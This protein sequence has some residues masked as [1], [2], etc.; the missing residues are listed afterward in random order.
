ML[1]TWMD[2]LLAIHNRACNH[3]PDKTVVTL[4]KVG[5]DVV[6]FV[7]TPYEETDL[8]ELLNSRP[9][10]PE[11]SSR[12]DWRAGDDLVTPSL[13]EDKSLT[14]LD[15]IK[16]EGYLN[17]ADYDGA[18]PCSISSSDVHYLEGSTIW[19]KKRSM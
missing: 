3:N 4:Q 10:V 6:E 15:L 17:L 2:R 14:L 8:V 9:G 13:P 19:Q 1:R 11:F 7:S 18:C 16:K 12:N 5:G